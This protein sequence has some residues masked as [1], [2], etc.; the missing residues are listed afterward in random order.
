MLLA[1]NNAI[2]RISLVPATATVSKRL[3]FR[4]ILSANV[5]SFGLVRPT[6]SAYYDVK[7]YPYLR[8]KL[9]QGLSDTSG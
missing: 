6:I 7:R 9:N 3:I 2:G 5:F 4:R 8:A 1:L